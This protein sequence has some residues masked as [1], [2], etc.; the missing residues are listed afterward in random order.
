MAGATVSSEVSY[1]LSR[2]DRSP[3]NSNA[4]ELPVIEVPNSDGLPPQPDAAAAP[5]RH[6]GIA[7][8]GG[9]IRSASF[10]AGVLRGVNALERELEATQSNKRIYLRF[11]FFTV[12]RAEVDPF[13][14][15]VS[16]G[17]YVGS[18]YVDWKSEERPPWAPWQGNNNV[19]F[20]RDFYKNFRKNVGY[21]VSCNNIFTALVDLIVLLAVLSAHV[22]IILLPLAVHVFKFPLVLTKKRASQS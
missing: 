19:S 4:V 11:A 22:L 20:Y 6:V 9:G 15:C 18:A 7:F 10:C 14:S 17:G 8:S 1:L 16:G 3:R 5:L 12:S 13:F 21:I 2:E